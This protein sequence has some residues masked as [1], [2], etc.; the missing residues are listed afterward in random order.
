MRPHHLLRRLW[1]HLASLARDFHDG[2][3]SHPDRRWKM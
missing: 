3:R 2:F 1:H